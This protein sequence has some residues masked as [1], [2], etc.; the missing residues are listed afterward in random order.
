M[1]TY[2]MQINRSGSQ[3]TANATLA[4]MV[5]SA[6]VGATAAIAQNDAAMVTEEN[7]THIAMLGGQNEVP[8]VD[9]PGTGTAFVRYDADTSRIAWTVEY[10]ELTGPAT[11]A[12][13]HGPATT[14]ETAGVLINL[15]QD[16]IPE[17]RF[18][19][20]ADITPEQAAQLN[21]GLLYVNIHTEANPGGEV[22]G[23]LQAAAEGA[24][25]AAPAEEAGPDPALLAELTNEGASVYRSRCA[26]CHGRDGEG[27]PPA[28]DAAPALAGRIGLLSVRTIV[29]QVVRGGD[30]MPAFDTLTDRQIAAVATYIRNSFGNSYGIA[31]EDEVAGFR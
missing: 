24:A 19:G 9:A 4:A 12:H 11:G 5:L 8:A 10:A 6:I 29:N 20:E 16:G 30:Y 23:Q 2:L 21:D 31:T 27:Q 18:E 15:G 3:R 26:G 17:G 22:R 7:A 13:I 14:E 28:Q 1:E 25:S